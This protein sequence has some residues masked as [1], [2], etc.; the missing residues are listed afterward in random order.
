MPE[1]GLTHSDLARRIG[2][3]MEDP[4]ALAAAADASR[5]EGRVDAAER[6]ADLVEAVAEKRPTL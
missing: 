1:P 2:A 3:L 4:D 5:G 6:L